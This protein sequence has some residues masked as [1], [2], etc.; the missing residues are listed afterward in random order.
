[1]FIPLVPQI[2]PSVCICIICT[3]L[4]TFYLCTSVVT[5][6]ARDHRCQSFSVGV[7][8]SPEQPN[9]VVECGGSRACLDP[10]ACSCVIMRLRIRTKIS[11]AAASYCCHGNSH[12]CHANFN[13]E[14]NFDCP[15]PSHS[16]AH[17]H[18]LTQAPPMIHNP[19]HTC[20]KV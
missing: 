13:F 17:K 19:H 1:M 20:T 15:P 5:S 18:T 3:I 9:A 6:T 4:T 10:L 11:R 8:S 7:N 14:F 12:P 16:P 2:V